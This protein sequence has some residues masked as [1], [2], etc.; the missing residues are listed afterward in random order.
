MYSRA[1]RARVSIRGH[2]NNKS[3]QNRNIVPFQLNKAT[4]APDTAEQL[5]GG[6]HEKLQKSYNKQTN[7]LAMEIYLMILEIL[8]KH[9]FKVVIQISCGVVLLFLYFFLRFIDTFTIKIV[10]KRQ[11]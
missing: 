3:H 2:L 11:F 4:N 7:P 8:C 10:N 1:P 9:T 6:G 5:W